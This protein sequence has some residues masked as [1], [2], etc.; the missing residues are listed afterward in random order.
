MAQSIPGRTYVSYG[1]S[2]IEKGL[3]EEFPF[4]LERTLPGTGIQNVLKEYGFSLSLVSKI[5][6][7]V[8][9]SCTGR[10]IITTDVQY[11]AHEFAHALDNTHRQVTGNWIYG[12]FDFSRMFSFMESLLRKNA[13][14]Y[15]RDESELYARAFE[16]GY[17]L[18]HFKE[19][20][21][22]TD[23]CNFFYMNRPEPSYE[24]YYYWGNFE[25]MWMDHI[26]QV[27]KTLL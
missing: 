8:G 22:W 26:K 11:V 20:G 16:I 15:F 19:T 13:R 5:K 27:T 7:K 21:K 1:A 24:L 14:Q 18:S 10:S 4:E 9:A 17:S 2:L 3:L 23:Y 25:S 6:N 12:S